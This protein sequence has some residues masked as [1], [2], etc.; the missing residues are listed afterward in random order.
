MG[1]NREPAA[2][3]QQN[4]RVRDARR[5]PALLQ[6]A[7][8]SRRRGA[9][10]IRRAR[11][12]GGPLEGQPPFPKNDREPVADLAGECRSM[13]GGAPRTR[14][15]RRARARRQAHVDRMVGRGR[16]RARCPAILSASRKQGVRM[17]P[18]RAPVGLMTESRRERCQLQDD[19]LGRSTPGASRGTR[20]G[21]PARPRLLLPTSDRGACES[22]TPAGPP[23]VPF[24]SSSP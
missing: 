24:C 22:Q 16:R 1:R 6:L 8:R 10:R 23:C 15:W 21:K 13:D 19:P 20:P 5:G 3:R 14:A 12:A 7:R 18:S 4:R 17:A 9:D 11:R 2:D